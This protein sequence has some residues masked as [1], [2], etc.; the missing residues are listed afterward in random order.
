MAIEFHR[1]DIFYYL[2]EK[3]IIEFLDLI[4]LGKM[5]IIYDNYELFSFLKSIRMKVQDNYIYEGFSC[6]GSVLYL[7]DLIEFCS[8]SMKIIPENSNEYGKIKWVNYNNNIKFIQNLM[9]DIRV[10]EFLVDM[11]LLDP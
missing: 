4:E 3:E 8:F 5:C 11:D 9:K 1:N 2:Y 7:C 10:C 6:L